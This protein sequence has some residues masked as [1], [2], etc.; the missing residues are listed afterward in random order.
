ME[1][2]QQQATTQNGLKWKKLLMEFLSIFSAV[3]LAF[4]LN[5][6]NDNRKVKN[7]E[8]N[9][10]KEVYNG[11]ELDAKDVELNVLGHEHGIRATNYFRRLLLGN[12]VNHDSIAVYRRILVRDFISIQNTSGYESLKSQGLNVIENDE[13]RREIISLYE[14]NYKLVEKIEEQYA[15][16]QFFTSYA[17]RFNSALA[18]NIEFDENQA[19]AGL[20]LPL[21]LTDKERKGLLLDLYTISE[22]R[23][24]TIKFYKKVSDQIEKTKKLIEKEVNMKR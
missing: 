4:A 1:E 23:T 5:N 3:L 24:F 17:S 22:D 16:Q 9:I 20:K 7:V 12:P 11:L 14:Y 18:P 10:L 8:T 15:A 21:T 13:L 6:W 2:P 19:V